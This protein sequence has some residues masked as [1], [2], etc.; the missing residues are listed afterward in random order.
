MKI[1]VSRSLSDAEY[2]FVYQIA[3][4]RCS[5]EKFVI[6]VAKKVVGTY[7]F[8]Y[9]ITAICVTGEILQSKLNY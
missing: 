9:I 4:S 5:F 6:K 3:L 7:I 8:W 1:I 2:D